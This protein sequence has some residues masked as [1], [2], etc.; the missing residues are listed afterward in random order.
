MLRTPCLLIWGSEAS[1]WRAEQGSWPDCCS[2]IPRTTPC[3]PR[4]ALLF[5][6][7]QAAFD[8]PLVAT[9]TSPIIHIVSHKSFST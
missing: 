9:D 5:E 8:Y 6:N 1:G 2:P 4:I 3:P 7:F